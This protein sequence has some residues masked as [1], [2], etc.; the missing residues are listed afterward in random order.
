[1]ATLGPYN[2][3]GFEIKEIDG[4]TAYI[5]YSTPALIFISGC[6][7]GKSEYFSVGGQEVVNADEIT[8]NYQTSKPTMYTTTSYACGV[9]RD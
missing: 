6:G 2:Q 1:M 9:F 5:F 7:D 4:K 3:G 8:I